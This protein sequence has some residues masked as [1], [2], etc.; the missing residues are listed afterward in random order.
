M[1]MVGQYDRGGSVH[2]GSTLRVPIADL[3]F[4][5]GQIGGHVG[6]PEKKSNA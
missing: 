3:D 2:Y 6:F 5:D 4:L 1:N